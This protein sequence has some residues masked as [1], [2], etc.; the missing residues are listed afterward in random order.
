MSGLPFNRV[1]LIV[2]DSL[3]IGALP[4]ACRY[5]DDGANTLA[6]IDREAGGISLPN[7]EQLGLGYLGDF[8]GIK[9]PKRVGGFYG[10]MAEASAGKDT[11]TGHWEM[12]G[13]VLERSFPTYPQGFPDDLVGAFEKE[14]GRKTL[15]NI[16]VS[17]T[18]II[19]TLG[20]KHLDTGYPIIYTSA[21]SVFQVAAHEAVIP[22]EALY[23]ICRTARSLLTGEHA[24]CRVIARPFV[25]EPGNFTRTPRR[26]DFS[27]KPPVPNLLSLLQE[28]GIPVIGVGKIEDIFAGVG[29]DRAVHTRGNT[30]GMEATRNLLE[31][32][33]T[34][35]IFTNLIDFDMLYGHRRDAAGYAEA[36]AEFD[37]WLGDLP[38]LPGDLLMITAD[39]G[40]DPTFRGF[41]HTREYVPLLVYS[42]Q[43]QGGGSLG[44]RSGHA[45]IGQTV[46]QIFGIPPLPHGEG[47][48]MNL[49]P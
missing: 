43:L 24:V 23:D 26:R 11:T 27:L 33:P 30:H 2:L 47:F 37:R 4:D 38:L 16:P 44:L 20:R 8:T 7:L 21:D 12:T 22:P 1:V 29:I 32:T 31:E 41:D 25:G 9:R 42:P 34:G 46:A 13:V 35:L 49:S 3:G 15:G 40:C 5:H 28:N 6:H 10:K 18:K 14:I 19:E 45:D 36:L 39:H 48:L 17:G